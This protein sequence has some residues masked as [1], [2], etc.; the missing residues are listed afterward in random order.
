MFLKSTPWEAGA[1][2]DVK[3]GLLGW[4]QDPPGLGPF[5]P[6]LHLPSVSGT[7]FLLGGESE[8]VGPE[9]P[10]LSSCLLSVLASSEDEVLLCVELESCVSG[11]D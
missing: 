4:A 7:P 5:C 6:S 11:R 8:G 10:W 3:C 9:L 2:H 1:F